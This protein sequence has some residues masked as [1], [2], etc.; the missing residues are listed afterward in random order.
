[1]T[2]W[3]KHNAVIV[4]GLLKFVQKVKLGL[5]WPLVLEQLLNVIYNYLPVLNLGLF[6]GRDKGM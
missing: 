4:V 2:L 6:W 5:I 3:E 1:M